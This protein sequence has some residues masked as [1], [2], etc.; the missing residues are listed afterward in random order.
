MQVSH[1]I[2]DMDGLLL[3]TEVKTSCMRVPRRSAHG[4]ADLGR[5]S[6]LTLAHREICARYGKEFTVELKVRDLPCSCAQ[7]L[8]GSLAGVPV[9]AKLLGLKSQACG[10][11]FVETLQLQGQLTPEGFL[12]QREAA[13]KKLW[14]TAEL[15]PGMCVACLQT[16]SSC[17]WWLSSMS[18]AA[19]EQT[20]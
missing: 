12:R 16:L 1:C 14:P 10:A 7:P 11:I 17:A 4:P 18:C 9:Q 19:Q 6:F 2:F 8:P 13:L 15:M 5:R 20:G 3:T